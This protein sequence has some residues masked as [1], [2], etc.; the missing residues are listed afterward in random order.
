MF[1]YTMEQVACAVGGRLVAGSP[2]MKAASAVIDSRNS[3]PGAI[4]FALPGERS[5]GHEYVGAAAAA[6]A[7]GAIVSRVPDSEVIASIPESFGLIAVDDVG[8]SLGRLASMHRGRMSTSVVAITGSAGKTT[9]KDMVASAL[10]ALSSVCATEGNMNNE[11]GLPLT[12]LRIEPDHQAVVVEMAMRGMGEIAELTAIARPDIGVVTN[13][14]TAHIACLGSQ[15]NI[16]LAKGELVS[17]LPLH[18][19]A[20]LNGDDPR[21]RAM[22]GL[23]RCRTLLYGFGPDCHVSARNIR[24]SANS[25]SFVL[26]IQGEPVGSHA[27]TVPLPGIHNVANALA[28]IAVGWRLGMTPDE[29]WRGLGAFA[30]SEMR[31]QFRTSEDGRVVIDDT[32]NANPASMMCAIDAA[33][34]YASGRRVV[35]VLGDML[36]LGEQ[37]AAYHSEVGSHAAEA[38]VAALVTM[39]ELSRHIAKGAIS[40]GMPPECVAVCGDADEV[41][42]EA[43]HLGSPGDIYLVKGSRG[44]RMEKVVEALARCRK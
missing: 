16:A 43:I 13:V 19:T 21:V 4:F 36:E 25:T 38:G 17:A 35:A 5:D 29:M 41:V 27:F 3:G 40:F 22:A 10:S 28:A 24:Q 33:M 15:D 23:A 26:M 18:G 12:L 6:G 37:S 11:L 7:A 20:I 8:V 1:D 34:Q 32:Y 31:M 9:T 39:G 2:S 30:P 44:M 14:G 42:R